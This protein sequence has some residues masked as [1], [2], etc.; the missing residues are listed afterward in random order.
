MIGEI[1]GAIFCIIFGFIV[2][3]L[4]QLNKA[5]RDYKYHLFDDIKEGDSDGKTD[6][7]KSDRVS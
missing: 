1:I 3:C 4:I 6:S 2:Y 5:L 7:R